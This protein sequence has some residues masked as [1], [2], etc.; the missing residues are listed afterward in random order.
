MKI[1]TSNITFQFLSK[2]TVVPEEVIS[3]SWIKNIHLIIVKMDRWRFSFFLLF[4]QMLNL[5]L[6]FH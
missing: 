3:C 6:P 4:A 1:F 5:S 2:E